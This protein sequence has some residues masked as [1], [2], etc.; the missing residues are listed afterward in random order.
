MTTINQLRY[1]VETC[2]CKSMTKAAERLYVSQPAVTK[3]IKDLE[4]KYETVLLTRNKAG[5]IPTA[6]GQV[7][8]THA[9]KVLNALDETD[10]AMKALHGENEVL[11]VGI[12]IIFAKL[13][14]SFLRQFKQANPLIDTHGYVFGSVELGRYVEDGT[15][16]VAIFGASPAVRAN[17]TVLLKSKSFFWT[18]KDNPLA[19]KD[20]I[21]MN[22]DLVAA[23]IA[24]FR[25]S[26]LELEDVKQT[27]AFP[28]S[29]IPQSN[30]V[31]S[32][33]QFS[34][35]RSA[36]EKGVASTFLPKGVLADCPDLVS[37][38]IAPAMDFSIAA[39]WNKNPMRSC[40][41]SLIDA[42]KVFIEE[43]DSGR[44]IDTAE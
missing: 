37:I 30:V 41:R 1:F 5:H 6:D 18:R 32:T 10:A 42:T 43:T 15:L 11:R 26:A 17:S 34:E 23:P 24:L 39:Y 19:S 8:Y 22:H 16:D 29:A 36:V 9:L 14:P 25:E 35:V 7:L 33:N 31:L 28:Q 4:K 2:N 27:E 40:V 21:D 3:S 20:I 12:S 44:I 38:P 13:Y